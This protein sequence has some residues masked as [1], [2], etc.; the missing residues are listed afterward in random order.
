MTSTPTSLVVSLKKQLSTA[1]TKDQPQEIASILQQLKKQVIAT[2]ELIRE[3]KIGVTVNKLKSNPNKAVADLAREIVKKWKNDVGVAASSSSTGGAA[4]SKP[5]VSGAASN[6]PSPSPAPASPAGPIH[7][8]STSTTKRPPPRT[9]TAPK[10]ELTAAPTTTTTTTTTTTSTSKTSSTPVPKRKQSLNS[11][12]RTHTTDGL[13]F[14]SDEY[15]LNDKTRDK[16]VEMIY[17]AMSFDSD[18]PTD[19]ICKRA[20]ALEQHV[21]INEPLAGYRAKIRSLYL[22]LKAANNP[23]L[24]ED[25]VSGEISVTRLYGMSPAEMASEEQQALNR[26]LAEEN[27]FKA[28]GAAPQQ[29]E[30]DAFQCG[31]CKQRRTMYYQM[32]TRSADEPMT[33]FVTC[34]K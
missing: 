20:Q 34:L 13:D 19:L 15:S 24:R 8:T 28:Q 5:P 29:A 31:K 3:T 18:A 14:G 22:N 32:Q 10:E 11:A 6:A 1:V 23:S 2:E 26:K 12:P 7:K 4:K 9:I 16:C 33:T 21:H 30:T 25:V 17:D 27:L